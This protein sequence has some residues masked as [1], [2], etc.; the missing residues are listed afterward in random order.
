MNSCTRKTVSHATERT[1][2]SRL[3][4]KRCNIVSSCRLPI[5]H[6]RNEQEAVLGRLLRDW[7]IADR[8][9]YSDDPRNL[10]GTRFGS[11]SLMVTKVANGIATANF[12]HISPR[13]SFIVD[14]GKLKRD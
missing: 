2:T 11:S 14:P 12:L 5:R 13:T 9:I 8:G 1:H 7:P 3:P 6:F 10:C 4:A